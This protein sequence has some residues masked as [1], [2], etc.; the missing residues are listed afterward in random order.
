[1]VKQKYFEHVD[2]KQL[3]NWIDSPAFLLQSGGPGFEHPLSET[4]LEKHME[5]TNNE[6]AEPWFIK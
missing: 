2:F 3:I 5:N 4:Q 6:R 1:M